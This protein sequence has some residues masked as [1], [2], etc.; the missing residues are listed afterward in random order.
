MSRL[1]ITASDEGFFNRSPLGFE[2]APNVFLSSL[3]NI[4][5]EILNLSGD[6]VSAESTQYNDFGIQIHVN[7]DL[8]SAANLGQ[9][10]DIT[11]E[12]IEYYRIEDGENVTIGLVD[13][14]HP[15]V[16]TA[17]YDQ[18][19]GDDFGWR[20]ELGDT[21]EDMVQ[22]VGFSF[23]GGEGNDV[24]HAH[25]SVIPVGARIVI[26]G[27]AGDDELHGSAGNDVIKGGV[28]NDVIID[29]AGENLLRGHRGDDFIKI[30]NGSLGSNARG[31]LGND[32]IISGKGADS[33]FGNAGH[34]KLLGNR[35]DDFLN[36]G[37]GR[38]HLD[39]GTGNDILVGS[40]GNDVLIGGEDADRFVFW[41][42]NN[43]DDIV[44][45]FEDGLDLLQFENVTAADIAVTQVGYDTVISWGSSS[46]TLEETSASVIGTDDF[47]FA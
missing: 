13:L 29:E 35:G 9:I 32:T 28:G 6:W 31:G 12:R 21:I 16:V 14:P 40:A 36:G 25:N 34:D 33:L 26:S 43:G 2:L 47:I 38:D 8:P 23:Q 44:S 24:F 45:D 46:V 11:V 15:T 30:G 10:V 18:F 17:T 1:E 4:D 7:G 5:G 37:Y 22:T 41:S 3:V 19:S 20:A 42:H 39:G 27:E